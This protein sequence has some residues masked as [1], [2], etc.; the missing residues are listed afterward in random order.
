MNLTVLDRQQVRR[1]D[2]IAI[3][4]FGISS[5]VLM[6]N[7]ARGATDRLCEA[8]IKGPVVICCGPGNNGGDGLVMARHLHLR[9]FSTRVLMFAEQEK[10]TQD[11]RSNLRILEKTSVPI[12][13]CPVLTVSDLAAHLSGA[14]WVVDAL[15]GTGATPP[16]RSPLDVVIPKMNELPVR[17][18]AI[19]IPTGLDCD[20][21]VVNG[22]VFE[23]EITCSFVAMKPVM[24]SETGQRYCGSVKIVDIGAPPEVFDFL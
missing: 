15:L 16:V 7:A 9:E 18:M 17:R 4:Q 10:L 22:A 6:E 12:T 2:K 19:D 5:L 24:Q 8:G 3:E 21:D 1:F 11:S 20:L 23:A 14:E 13:W